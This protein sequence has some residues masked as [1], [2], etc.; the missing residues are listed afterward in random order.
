[1]PG[2]DSNVMESARALKRSA[3]VNALEDMTS[4]QMNVF[5]RI[6][7]PMERESVQKMM[8]L[9]VFPRDLLVMGNVMLECSNV[10]A[11]AILNIIK[12]DTDIEN[13]RGGVYQDGLNAMEHVLMDTFHVEALVAGQTIMKTPTGPVEIYA[14]TKPSNVME[15]VQMDL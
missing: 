15:N 12:P 13:A 9:S 2:E 14:F 4:V 1:M 6:K 10:A 11:D 3:M 5:I 8:L 7:E